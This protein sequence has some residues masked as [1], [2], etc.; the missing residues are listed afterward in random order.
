MSERGFLGKWGPNHAADPIVTRFNP[1]NAQL[2]VAAIV[3]QAADPTRS[4]R[5]LRNKKKNG[6]VPMPAKLA[7]EAVTRAA[8]RER[9]LLD[10]ITCMVALMGLADPGTTADAPAAA[11][12]PLVS[13]V[14][15]EVLEPTTTC[16]GLFRISRGAAPRCVR[17]SAR[18]CSPRIASQGSWRRLRGPWV[19]HEGGHTHDQVA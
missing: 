8:L 12:V 14:V 5:G 16:C 7:A 2:Q 9:G 1:Q 17:S 13:R 11:S 15:D 3:R 6:V 10:D 19:G 18:S 4:L